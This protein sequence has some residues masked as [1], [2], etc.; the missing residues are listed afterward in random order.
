M[1]PSVARRIALSF[2]VSLSLCRAEILTDPSVASRTS[3]DFIVIGAGIGGNVIANRL[4]ENPNWNVL[5]L[6]AGPSNE[7]VIYAEIP[8]M[9]A[10]L[11]PDTAYDWN[12]TTT[13]QVGLGGRSIPYPRGYM[14]GGSSSVNYLIYN[15]G[16][17]D[18][19]DRYAAVTGD[20]GWSWNSMKPYFLKHERFTPPVDN[21]N[22]TGQMDPS[23]HGYN[24][25]T[26]V[27]LY[28]YPTAI[29][30]RIIEAT[31][32]LGGPHR[33]NLDVNTGNPLGI[34]WM[35]Y[36][37]N[38]PRRDSSAT[39]YLAPQFLQ[40]P[41]LHVVLGAH[42]SRILQVGR[43]NSPFRTVEYQIGSGALQT[44]TAKKEV[45]LAGGTVGTPRVLLSS[46]IGPAAELRA[47][48]ITPIVDLASVGKNL[49]DHSF[50]Y[51][52]FL[53]NSTNTF[54]DFNRSPALQQQG[55]AFWESTGTGPLVDIIGSHIGFIRLDSNNSI[56]QTVA[57]PSAGPTSGHHEFLIGNGQLHPPPTGN[58]I[59]L[60]TIVVSPSSRGS[61]TLNST[62]PFAPPV[63]DPGLL[64]DEFDRV[65]LR[66]AIKLAIQFTQAPVWSDYV[67]GPT[68]GLAIALNA[69]TNLDGAIDQYVTNHTG[70]IWH[71][72]GT[73]SMSPV[74]APWGVVDP[75]LK[76][77]KVTGLRIVDASVFPYIP[78]MH[79]QV[80]IYVVAERAADF[81]KAEYH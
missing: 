43:G 45:I 67:I 74:G 77:K 39:S 20:Q 59:G 54:D 23:I 48:G 35:P 10:H 57:D 69:T 14:L 12:Y 40:R 15:R 70:T 55:V 60:S 46:G 65:V 79:P 61:V 6:E 75:D 51:S 24:G 78:S 38:G 53:V 22:T 4:T 42:V 36:T 26:A 72:V 17:Q 27:T 47:L 80:P 71:P 37:A 66:E 64:R 25:M 63:I 19:W 34:G 16:S 7:G 73:A 56:F 29:D 30:G 3:Y 52:P 18:D 33:F 68:G 76:V 62:N 81:I 58:F 32:Q 41:N 13:P 1:R 21:H 8:F 28:G 11:E 9:A 31:Q 2:L 5:V 49:S 50:L 44:L